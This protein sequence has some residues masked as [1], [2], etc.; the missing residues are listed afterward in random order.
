MLEPDVAG[1]PP[2]TAI[3]YALTRA[4]PH[5]NNSRNAPRIQNGFQVT[6]RIDSIPWRFAVAMYIANGDLYEASPITPS[7]LGRDAPLRVC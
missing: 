3:A 4:T 6:D 2:C 5:L 7:C 1:R